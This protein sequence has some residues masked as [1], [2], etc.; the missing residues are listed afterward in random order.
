MHASP[1]P[2]ALDEIPRAKPVCSFSLQRFDTREDAF[3]MQASK[4]SI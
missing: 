1:G 2:E 4:V 3:Q